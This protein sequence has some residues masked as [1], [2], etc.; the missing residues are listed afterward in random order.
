MRPR[1]AFFHT[2]SLRLQLLAWLLIPLCFIIAFNAY[3]AY[4]N[5][6][7]TAGVITDRLLLAAARVLAEQVHEDNGVV[8]ALI[9][10]SALGIF[11]SVGQDRALYRISAP[12]GKL[13]AGY[14]DVPLPPREPDPNEPVFFSSRFR[15]ADVRAVAIA[16]P[17]ASG[18]QG[19]H[20]LIIVG[21]TL[22]DED[23]I[24][25][26]IWQQGALQQM[27]L[28]AIAA[29]LAWFGLNR[30]L[31]PLLALRD[32]IV[33]RDPEVL[34]PFADMPVHSEL[35]PLISALND[36]V[37][38]VKTQIGAQRRFIADAAHQLRTP[39]TLL[40]TQAGVGLRATAADLKHEALAAIDAGA[41]GM[42]RLANQLLALA[43]SEPGGAV[44]ARE[45]TDLADIARR[46]LEAR[47]ARALDRNIDLGLEASPAPVCGDAAML[48]EMIAN[49]VDN[50]LLYVPPG[51]RVTIGV[52]ARGGAAYLRVEDDG[53]GIP[54]HE[55]PRVFERFYRVLGT[56]V[57]GSGLGLAIV[58]EIVRAHRAKIAMSGPP[59]GSGLVVEIAFP[60]D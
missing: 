32:Q 50:A 45:Q 24:V 40:K 12:D 14:P 52:A 27:L 30:G 54:A 31:A 20:V 9:A 39:L 26:E 34:T 22:R 2:H 41:D 59:D 21:E 5:A 29:A 11:A 46:V 13:V 33:G 43:R 42:T 58:R 1:P 38:R 48:G 57:D 19:A 55:M 23:R 17:L 47:A 36:A 51:G 10:P 60:L 37:L 7:L 16:Q 35:A 15:S 44:M 18:R 28:V 4:A 56:G 3:A 8:E 6:R 25:A 49:L 53:P